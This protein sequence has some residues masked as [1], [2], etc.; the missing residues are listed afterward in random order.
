MTLP[1]APFALRISLGLVLAFALASIG[2]AHPQNMAADL[3]M[4]PEVAI[5][6]AQGGLLD[7]LCLP[8]RGQPDWPGDC[9]LCHLP[10]VLSLHAPDPGF[11]PVARPARVIPAWAASAPQACRHP[12]WQGR[13]PPVV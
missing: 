5:Y 4:N 3:R 9:P 12:A 10:A 11:Q 13:A 1:R 2:L 6:L 7:D 8:E